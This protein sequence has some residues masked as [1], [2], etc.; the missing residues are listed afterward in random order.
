MAD[1]GAIRTSI[2][3]QIAVNAYPSL[4]T[5]A[6]YLDAINP[7][8]LLVIPR[9]P[10][11]KIGVCLGEGI[12]DAS[13][14]PLS[15]TEFTLAGALV[16]AHADIIQNVQQALDIWLGFENIPNTAVSVAMAIAMDPTLGGTVEWCETTIIDGYGPI[17]WNGASYF[18]ARIHWSV[19]AR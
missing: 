14:R 12:L 4:N 2:A 10:V 13:G 7:P 18:G 15:P 16:V 6:D 5:S 1:L 19:S 9:A 3:S 11:A 8:T 17:E